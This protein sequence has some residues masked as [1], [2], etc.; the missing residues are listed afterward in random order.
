MRIVIAGGK[1]KADYLIRLFMSKGHQMVVINDDKEFCTYLCQTHRI[2]VI[3][4]DPCKLYVM[5]NAGIDG[6]DIMIAL[7]PSD[8]DNLAICQTAKRLYHIRRTVAV[9]G[10]PKSVDIFKR[11]GVSTAISATYLIAGFIEQ[12]STVENLVSS[13][14]V[15]QGNVVINELMINQKSPMAGRKLC[16]M[17]LGEDA[18]ICCIIRGS[19]IIVPK[20]QTD[21]QAN[22]KLL[23]LSTPASQNRVIALI[24]G[25]EQA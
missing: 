20:G 19:R 17:D 7:K 10:N 9:V 11:L 6:F 4:G 15:D 23:V 12:L 1:T 13:L 21:V 16:D 8:A 24:M 2:P 5:D 14:P 3:H 22:D 18:I 25:K